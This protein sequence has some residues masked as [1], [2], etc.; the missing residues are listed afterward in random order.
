MKKVSPDNLL[1]IGT[2]IRP[3]GLEGLLRIWSYAQSEKSFLDA[4][5]IFLK[6]GS[7]K[8]NEYS[9]LSVRPHKQLFLMKLKELSSFDEAEKF[10]GADILIRKGSLRREN[11]DEFF[12]Y[13]LLGLKVYMNSGK[14]IGTIR[15]ILPTKS[16]DIYVVREGK[17]EVLIPAIHDMVEEID[18]INKRMIISEME[19]LLDLNEV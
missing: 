1:I 2:V 16:N 12:W 6:S 4:G 17:A 3:H 10:R 9:L 13:E 7:G 15:N 14:Y 19:G 8:T 11:E 18:L 5:T